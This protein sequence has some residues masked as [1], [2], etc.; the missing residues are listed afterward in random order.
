MIYTK[1]LELRNK[2]MYTDHLH[3]VITCIQEEITK[4]T[5]LSKT[6]IH[7]VATS[8][9]AAAILY[10]LVLANLVLF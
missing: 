10:L 1:E 5:E 9:M 2:L 4:K 6:E 3:S 8:V 7:Y